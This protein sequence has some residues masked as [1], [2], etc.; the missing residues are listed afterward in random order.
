MP[1]VLLSSS[2][3]WFYSKVHLRGT[4][5]VAVWLKFC[6]TSTE[7]AGLLRTGAQDVHLD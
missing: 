3:F 1:V 7:T 5:C 6:F 2:L 4:G